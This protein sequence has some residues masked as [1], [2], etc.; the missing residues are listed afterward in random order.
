MNEKH[1]KILYAIQHS[2]E[3]RS[4]FWQYLAGSISILGG[5][6]ILM[7]LTAWYP[8]VMAVI[9]LIFGASAILQSMESEMKVFLY[10]L[11]HDL[12]NE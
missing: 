4:G 10:K 12:L 11:H 8:K 1:Q 2:T 3:S 5:V 6:L 9:L 7:F